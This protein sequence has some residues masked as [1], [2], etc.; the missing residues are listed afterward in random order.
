MSS[1]VVCT[2]LSGEG[3]LELR[4]LEVQAPGPGAVRIAVRAASV[5]FPDVLMVRGQYQA[6]AEPPFV[7]GTECAG[8]VTEAGPQAGGL[9]VGDRVLAVVGTGAFATQAVATPP[10]QQVHRI[11]AEIGD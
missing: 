1:A 11:L 7:A 2:D 8:V 9:A 4:D 10:L 3:T 5:N 6:R